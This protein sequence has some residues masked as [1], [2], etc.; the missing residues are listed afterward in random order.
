MTAD[1]FWRMLS[2]N[3]LCSGLISSCAAWVNQIQSKHYH[4]FEVQN[5]FQTYKTFKKIAKVVHLLSASHPLFRQWTLWAIFRFQCNLLCIRVFKIIC[6]IYFPNIK[7]SDHWER[8]VFSNTYKS[9]ILVYWTV[10][11][12]ILLLWIRSP[13]WMKHFLWP[14]CPYLVNKSSQI[15]K[16]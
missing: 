1:A 13:L 15:K 11:I 10:V 16:I 9:W 4:Y 6:H 7:V 12:N 3:L 14:L 8:A 2:P 5:E